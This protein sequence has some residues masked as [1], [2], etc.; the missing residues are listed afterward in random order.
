MQISV[1]FT[2]AA[3]LF[4]SAVTAEDKFNDAVALSLHPRGTYIP[5][6]ASPFTNITVYCWILG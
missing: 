6:D 4:A 3:G 2:L 1:L 5:S